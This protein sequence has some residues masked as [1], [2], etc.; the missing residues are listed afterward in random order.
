MSLSVRAQCTVSVSAPSFQLRTSLRACE[1]TRPGPRAYA[2]QVW[3][4]E[5]RP[6]HIVYTRLY[7][8]N[9]QISSISIHHHLCISIKN[10]KIILNRQ[11]RVK[12]PVQSQWDLGK[13]PKSKPQIPKFQIQRGKGE[14]VLC[15][16]DSTG[17]IT[18]YHP[19]PSIITSVSVSRTRK[20]F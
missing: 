5:P 2:Y 15:T 7:R 13:S 3:S 6:G 20:Q 4:S 12:I 14:G 11:A 19:Y 16:L 1:H 9:N 10:Q 17:T 8:D 18:R